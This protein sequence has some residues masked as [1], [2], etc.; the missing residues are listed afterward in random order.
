MEIGKEAAD[1]QWPFFYNSSVTFNNCYQVNIDADKVIGYS[2][3][4]YLG[5]DGTMVGCYG[6]QNPFRRTP[7]LPRVTKSAV[8]IDAVNKKLN[9]TLTLSKE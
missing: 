1:N 4:S 2:S 5:N 6:G 8:Q 7:E 9:V 3:S